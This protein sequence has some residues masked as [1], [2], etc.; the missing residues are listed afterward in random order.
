MKER[1]GSAPGEVANDAETFGILR[2][3]FI[4][5]T[6]NFNVLALITVSAAAAETGGNLLFKWF[7]FRPRPMT[8]I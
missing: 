7:Q 5:L 2:F 8:L 6:D 1:Y 4:S 3:V